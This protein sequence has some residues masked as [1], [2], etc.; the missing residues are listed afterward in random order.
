MARR[1]AAIVHIVAVGTVGGGEQV[2]VDGVALVELHGAEV[3]AGKDKEQDHHQR[4]HGVVVIRNGAQEHGKA[5]DAGAFG[6]RGC[7]GSRPAGHRRNDAHRGRSGVDQ[8]G[9]L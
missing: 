4:E 6:H 9:Q 7:N 3:G 2:A 8:V 1:G 5:V